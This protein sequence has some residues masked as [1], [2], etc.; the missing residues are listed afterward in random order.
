LV[1]ELGLVGLGG[2]DSLDSSLV[3]WLAGTEEVRKRGVRGGGEAVAGVVRG[4]RMGHDSGV[5][6]W[7]RWGIVG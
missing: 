5:L 6:T 1:V 3:L 2:L 7:K 4:Q